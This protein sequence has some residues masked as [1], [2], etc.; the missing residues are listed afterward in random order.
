MTEPEKN[1][2]SLA[3]LPLMIDVVLEYLALFI[4]VSFMVEAFPTKVLTTEW[5]RGRISTLISTMVLG[6]VH[7]KE[8]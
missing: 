1:S 3:P 8:H 7:S 2:N 4:V 6:R 5:Q